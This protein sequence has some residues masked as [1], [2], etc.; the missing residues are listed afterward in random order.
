MAHL[1]FELTGTEV[2]EKLRIDKTETSR[3]VETQAGILAALIR[4]N[5]PKKS[6]DLRSG[7]VPSPWEEKTAY[8][9]K[10]VREVYFDYRMNDIFVKYS[11]SGKRYYYPASQEYGF[12]IA[13]QSTAP[14]ARPKRDRVPGKYFMRD[15]SIEY[16]PAF[17]SGAHKLIDKVAKNG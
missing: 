10:V 16:A 12:R 17:V 11:K 14:G 3:F 13:R 2:L 8:P 6:G 15:T 5:G 1:T 7:I 4:S 9:G